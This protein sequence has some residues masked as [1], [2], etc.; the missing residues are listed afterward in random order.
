MTM[1]KIILGNFVLL[2]LKNEILAEPPQGSL[3]RYRMTN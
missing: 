3:A 2:N 1:D